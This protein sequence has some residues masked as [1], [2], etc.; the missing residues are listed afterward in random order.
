MPIISLMFQSG[1]LTIVDYDDDTELYRLDYPNYEVKR[2]F[3]K[4]FT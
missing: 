1:Y 2:S 3:S 4:I